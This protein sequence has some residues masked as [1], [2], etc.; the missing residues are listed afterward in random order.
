[1]G[2]LDH[3]GGAEYQYSKK[4]VYDAIIQAVPTIKGLK[5][6]STDELSYRIMVKAG[7]SWS[8]WGENIPI[9]VIEISPGKTRVE[10][11]STPKTGAFGGGALDFGKNRA[12]I[13]KILNETSKIL[14]TKQPS[15][16]QSQANESGDI[17][18]KLQKLKALYDQKLITEDDYNKRKN[19]ILTR[20]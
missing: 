17:S 13:E 2:F 8:S 19:E 14:S 11:I 1:M 10:I 12:N 3:K 4:D 9:N 5:V 6:D 18:V 20:L 15:P 7:I 16:L